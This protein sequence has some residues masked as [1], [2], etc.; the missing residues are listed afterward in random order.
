M[1]EPAEI[2][3]QFQRKRRNKFRISFRGHFETH[4][5]SLL[6]RLLVCSVV[7][8]PSES[9]SA[10]TMAAQLA[11]SAKSKCVKPLECLKPRQRRRRLARTWAGSSAR[12]RMGLSMELVWN[13]VVRR[14]SRPEG[15]SGDL[16][17]E[18]GEGDEGD[19]RGRAGEEGPVLDESVWRVA[20]K[21]EGQ[22]GPQELQLLASLLLPNHN[23]RGRAEQLW[24]SPGGRWRGRRIRCQRGGR[25]RRM[26][27]RGGS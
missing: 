6:T 24:G 7:F 10:I 15:V 1:H 3:L 19:G 12:W 20:H 21:G 8:A 2:R 26:S 23:G 4:V 14:R 17:S 18:R 9:N 25:R 27:R 11:L 13:R 16:G 22:G 5:I